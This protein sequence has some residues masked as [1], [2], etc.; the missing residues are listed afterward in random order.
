MMRKNTK[1]IIKQTTN[2]KIEPIFSI[3]VSRAF[4]F[5]RAGLGVATLPDLV[6]LM[7]S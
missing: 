3:L 5:S 4:I 6:A 1:S 7:L 2:E